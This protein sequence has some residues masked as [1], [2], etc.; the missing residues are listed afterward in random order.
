MPH[1]LAGSTAAILLATA[2]LAAAVPEAQAADAAGSRTVDYQGYQLQVPS[3]WQVVDL[4]QNPNACVRF[5]QNAVYLGTPGA[6]QDC[7]AH[8]GG[9]LTDA[10]VVQSTPTPVAGQPAAPVVAPGAALPAQVLDAGALS[11][12]LRAQLQGTG[13]QV[14][15]NYGSSP[16]QVNAILAAAKVTASANKPAARAPRSLMATPRA[17]AN[18]AATVAPR[19]NGLGAGFDACTAPSAAQMTN[20]KS[21]S[22]FSSVGIYIGGRR[23]CAQPNLTA[24]WVSDRTNEGWSFLPIYVGLDASTISGDA[25]TARS[26]GAAAANDAVT[27][28]QSLGFTS[29]SVLYND[30]ES[31]SSTSYKS[32]VL[33]YFSGW[34]D[35]IHAANYRSGVYTSA[36][37]GITDLASVYNTPGY[38]MPD[39]IWSASWGTAPDTTSAAVGLTGPATGY[40]PGGRRV[41]QYV[42]D[43]SV[44]YGG[45]SGSVDLDNVNVNSEASGATMQPG[46]QLDPGYSISSASMKLVMQGDGNL[47][48]Y[49]VVGGNQGPAMWSTGTSGNPGAYALMQNDGNLVV[50]RPNGTAAWSSSTWYGGGTY[51]TVQDDGNFVVYQPNGGPSTGGALWSSGTNSIGST[52]NGGNWLTSGH[53]TKGTL[54]SLLMQADGNLV[55]YRN[56]DGSALWSSNSSG[57]P[58]AYMI[59]QNDGNLVVYRAGGGASTGGALWSSNTWYSGGTYATLQ[60]DGNFVVYRPGGSPTAGG[61]L[62]SSNTYLNAS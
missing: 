49:A 23:G 7:P 57:N 28:A 56:R 27:Q 36:G 31:Y 40:W 11:H 34:T 10:L 62:W 48:A 20:W 3:N 24:G 4:A 58:G 39:V 51:A 18:A 13:L 35:A 59:M 54:T 26:Q 33:N 30:M 14:T 22:P 46:Q 41:H 61:S 55:I 50:Y 19:T 60:S 5:D 16:Q 38:S 2:G 53:W 44:S 52:F 1:R 45:I 8:L 15:A 47:V 9:T 25:G 17:G 32:Q 29:G 43:T 42:G 37:S 6:N 12:Q 21:N